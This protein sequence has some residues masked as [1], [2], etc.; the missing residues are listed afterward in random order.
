VAIVKQRLDWAA[1]YID[2]P[3]WCQ[4]TAHQLGFDSVA[5]IKKDI[6]P[7][8]PVRL[9][10]SGAPATLEATALVSLIRRTLAFCRCD[11]LM[12]NVTGGRLAFALGEPAY[13][14]VGGIYW[15]SHEPITTQILQQLEELGLPLATVLH[16][17]HDI[18]A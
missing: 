17:T 5:F 18:T 9:A 2:E 12:L 13:A 1:A 15:E 14:R 6:N 16:E 10:V 7:Y 8:F 3:H 4:R 11:R